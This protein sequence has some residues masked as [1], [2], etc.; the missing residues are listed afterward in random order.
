MSEVA[1][2][3]SNNIAT[4]ANRASCTDAPKF[5]LDL[6][7]SNYKGLIY[8][9][10]EA[11]MDYCALTICP[12]CLGRTRFDR[13][14][15]IGRSSVP[16]CVDALKAAVV[17]AKKGSD[18]NRYREALEYIRMAAPNEPEAAVDEAWVNATEK[19]NKATT[20]QL[21]SELKGYKNN[22]VKESIRVWTTVF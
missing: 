9:P 10:S 1:P 19:S 11:P 8:C 20:R 17:E 18:V 13:L 14:L 15:L 4:F 5:D 22:L 2:L 6:Y 21:E 7:I 3:E 12:V 16:L